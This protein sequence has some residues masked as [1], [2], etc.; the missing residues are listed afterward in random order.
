M[1]EIRTR[2]PQ[3]SEDGLVLAKTVPPTVV[4][5]KVLVPTKEKTILVYEAADAGG[6]T[7]GGCDVIPL[8]TCAPQPA[9]DCGVIGKACCVGNYCR[10]GGCD[11]DKCVTCGGLTQP[12][13]PGPS[14]SNGFTCDQGECKNCGHLNQACCAN[15]PC[16]D[17]LVCNTSNVCQMQQP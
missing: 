1:K 15:T 8:P 7:P 6:G 17:N 13:C 4:D 2:L 3:I 12:C 5:G 14:C 9:C 16:L 10:E 11:M